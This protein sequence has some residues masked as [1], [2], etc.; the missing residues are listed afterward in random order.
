VEAAAASNNLM[1]D[2]RLEKTRNKFGRYARLGST[3]K[4][5]CGGELDGFRCS[6]CNGKC[7]VSNGCNCSGCMLLDVQKK[8]LPHGWLVNRDG[9]SARRSG[10]G[11]EKFY[12]GRMVMTHDTRTDGYCGPTNGEQCVA[13]QRLNEQQDRRYGQIWTN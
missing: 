9:A 6:C 11:S 4:F 8:Q 3:G 13:C 12:C 1:P 10:D 5:Y 2:D 7:G